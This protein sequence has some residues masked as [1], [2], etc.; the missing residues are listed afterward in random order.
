MRF[1]RAV[2][3]DMAVYKKRAQPF[4][5]RLAPFHLY[6]RFS[7]GRQRQLQVTACPQSCSKISALTSGLRN[8]DGKGFRAIVR[9]ACS[10][11]TVAIGTSIP[12]S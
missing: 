8:I 12:A 7:N 5:K 9:P 1:M 6:C 2:P 4:C 11:G 3:A 10:T